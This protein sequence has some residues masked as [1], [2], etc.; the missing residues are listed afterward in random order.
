VGVCEALVAG[1]DAVV[2]PVADVRRVDALA[3]R[4]TLERA[5][6]AGRRRRRRGGARHP[7]AVVRTA[8][9]RTAATGSVS[10]A[11]RHRHRA[12]TLDRRSP[13]S[14][15]ESSDARTHETTNRKLEYRALANISRSHYA[16]ILR[17]GGKLVGWLVG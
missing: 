15:A 14:A 9:S 5:V 1:V 17:G 7:R 6:A 11:H 10:R 13:T 16:V 2:H 12:V 8:A 4:Q 3:A